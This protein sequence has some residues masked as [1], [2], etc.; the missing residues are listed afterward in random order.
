ML[1]SSM[2]PPQ[3]SETIEKVRR[4]SA[5]SLTRRGN[6][7]MSPAKTPA[8]G[9]PK[10]TEPPETDGDA[11]G[12]HLTTQRFQTWRRTPP[13]LPEL[14]LR[15]PPA[16]PA[17]ARGP[18][19]AHP[20]SGPARA[21]PPP[22]HPDRPY[23]S[24]AT[25]SAPLSRPAGHDQPAR[26]A[27]LRFRP[28]ESHPLPLPCGLRSTRQGLLERL[29]AEFIAFLDSDRSTDST[30]SGHSSP[31]LD[32]YGTRRSIPRWKAWLTEHPRFHF[33]FTPTSVPG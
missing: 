27:L 32:N 11:V 4:K 23:C 19:S 8:S 29:F 33:H 12:D 30:P 9:R 15:K 13:G 16:R 1:R 21:P 14:P 18:P 24:R 2:Y 31:I 3:T 10:A 20:R 17:P 26:P 28:G 22:V 25:P 7:D 6:A 5:E